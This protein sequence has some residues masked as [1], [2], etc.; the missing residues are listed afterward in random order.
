VFHHDVRGGYT[1][2]IDDNWD[3]PAFLF[4]C[5]MIG[6]FPVLFV[7]WKV[8]KKTRWL[9]PG[10]VDLRKDV[11]EIEAYTREFVAEPPKYDMSS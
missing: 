3:I 10:E 5:T 1:V 8:L 7:G 6:V 9:K 4:S 2:F 11:E